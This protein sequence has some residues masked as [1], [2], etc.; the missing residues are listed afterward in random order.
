MEITDKISFLK[1]ALPALAAGACGVDK[2][3][4]SQIDEFVK[5]V[6]ENKIPDLDI[7]KT[8]KLANVMCNFVATRDKKTSIDTDVIREYFLF[9]HNKVL[10]DNA[11][12][13]DHDIK[14][15][16]TYARKITNIEEGFAI[17]KTKIGEEKYSTAFLKDA[18]VGDI[19]AVHFS[20]ITERISAETARKMN[21][22]Q[23]ASQKIKLGV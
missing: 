17:V 19:V 4:K 9:E 12:L 5:Q 14:T 8:F 7:E 1:Y 2:F 18:K 23:N 3:S 6:S 13:E 10:D 16:K 15:C 20:F 22:L 11:K 21:S